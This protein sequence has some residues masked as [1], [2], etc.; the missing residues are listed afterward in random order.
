MRRLLPYPL[1]AFCLFVMW[2]LLTQSFSPGQVALGASFAILGTHAMAAL[3]PAKPRINKLGSVVK[4]AAIVA[5]DI[6]RSN[7]AVATII[8][9]PRKERVAGFVRLPLDLK[10]REGLAVLAV[11][12]TSTP[13]TI[14]VDFDRARS[15]LLVHVLDLVDEDEWIRLI[16]RRY[17]SL[18]MEIFGE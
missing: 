17:E 8:L 4:L 11:I 16:K 5:V 15:V 7:L 18:L 14:W 2:L 10:S 13:G 1:L 6:V 12:I 9:F 3:K